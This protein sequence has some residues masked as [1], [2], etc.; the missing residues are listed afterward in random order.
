MIRAPHPN[1]DFSNLSFNPVKTNGIYVSYYHDG[2]WDEGRMQAE[3][4][5]TVH[6]LSTGVNYGQQAFEGMKAYRRQDGGVQFFRPF[7]NARRFQRSCQRLMMPEVSIEKFIEAISRSVVYNSEYVPPYETK[8]TLYVRPFILGIGPN[9]I[10]APSKD[11]LFG[12]VTMPVGLLFKSGLVPIEF[13]TTEFDRAAANGTGTVKVGGNYAASMY[14]NALAKSQGFA[15][16]L[17]LDPLTHTKIDEGGAANFFAV[18]PE[19]VF[20]TPKS[21]SILP[22]VTKL[23]LLY[24]ARERLGMKIEEREI[25]VD[26]LAGFAEAGTCG[27]AAIITPISAITHQGVRHAFPYEK[28]AGPWTKKLYDLLIGIQF[29]DIAAPEGWMLSV[30]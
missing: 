15:D 26:R 25:F 23:S 28:T 29:G 9:L 10:L 13:V 17:Y 8:A 6:A 1:V 12:V 2:A 27:T 21:T 11:Y 14:P 22:S 20:V 16:C 30:N 7:E 3:D 24:L 4:S 5:I 18:T 19:G